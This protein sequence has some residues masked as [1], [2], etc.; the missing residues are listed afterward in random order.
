MHQAQG[1]KLQ[2]M[3]WR[4]K[5]EIADREVLYDIL[6]SSDSVFKLKGNQC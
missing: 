2:M 5:A 4:I 3:S 6:R 1:R